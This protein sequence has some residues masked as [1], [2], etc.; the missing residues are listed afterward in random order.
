M[1]HNNRNE[2][3]RRFT[4]NPIHIASVNLLATR[5]AHI[6]YL[7]VNIVEHPRIAVKYER[8]SV[9]LQSRRLRK[10]FNLNVIGR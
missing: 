9:K 7:A 1:R 5:Q 3:P 6:D 2:I 4:G 10:Y 8:K